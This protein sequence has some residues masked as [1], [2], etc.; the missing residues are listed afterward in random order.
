MQITGNWE[1]LHTLSGD[2]SGVQKDLLDRLESWAK[3]NSMQFSKQ[4]WKVLQVGKRSQYHNSTEWEML[5]V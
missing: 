2:R 4:K 3:G 5:V 1:W